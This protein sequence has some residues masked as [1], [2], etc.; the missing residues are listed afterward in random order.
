MIILSV[1]WE[2]EGMKQ[3]ERLACGH[4]VIEPIHT[5]LFQGSCS[6][7]CHVATGRRRNTNEEIK[8]GIS[9][10]VLGTVDQSECIEAWRGR[11]ES[12]PAKD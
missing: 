2:N 5:H 3:M 1:R 4:T 12:G 6:Y 8:P 10:H 11:V 7:Q 9:L